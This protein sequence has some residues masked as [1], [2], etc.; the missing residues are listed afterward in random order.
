MACTEL[1]VNKPRAS[2]VAVINHHTPGQEG[3]K[4]PV[5]CCSNKGYQPEIQPRLADCLGEKLAALC[6]EVAALCPEVPRVLRK[7][8]VHHRVHK[9]PTLFPVLRQMNPVHACTPNAFKIP[10]LHD[11]P[12]GRGASGASA[13][14]P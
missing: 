12:L 2:S 13:D 8:K 1:V 4:G 7:P 10:F 5:R 3:S 14:G 11:K 9:S 6:P